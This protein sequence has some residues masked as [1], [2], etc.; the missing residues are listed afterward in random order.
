MNQNMFEKSVKSGISGASAMTIQ[1]SSLMWLRTTMNYQYKF[2][3]SMYSAITKLY[4]D[5]GI[6]RFYKGYIP[7]LMIGP[8]SRFGDT[9]TNELSLQIFNNSNIPLYMQTGCASMMTGAWR[10]ITLPL[11]TWKTSL[12][13]HGNKG[14]DIVKYKIKNEGIRGLYNGS[15]ASSTATIMGHFPW[16]VT[17]NYMNLYIPRIK[18]NDEPIKALGRNALIGFCSSFVS[19]TVSNSMRVIKTYKQ[20]HEHKIKYKDVVLNIKKTD[21]IFG[22]MFR[23]LQT[24]IFTNG[25]QGIIFSIFYKFISEKIEN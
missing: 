16:F 20:T 2:G 1:V 11:D 23:G 7:A 4:N 15:L 8:I 19:D 25:L 22:L 13:V 24:K 21:G 14:I 3:G 12:Q 6:R 9:F 10:I 5:G 17:Y 18:Y